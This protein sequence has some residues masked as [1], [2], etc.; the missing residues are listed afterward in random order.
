ML[1]V[2]ARLLFRVGTVCALV[3]VMVGCAGVSASSSGH[4][5]PTLALSPAYPSVPLGGS[6]Q[7]SAIQSGSTTSTVIWAVNGVQSGNSASGTISKTGLYVAPVTAPTGSVLVTATSSTDST[8]YASTT[9][10]LKTSTQTVAVSISPSSPSLQVGGGQQF[11][12]TVTGTS[13]TA[14]TWLVNGVQNGNS[15]YGTITSAGLYTA[16]ATVPSGGVATVTAKSVADSTKSASA[17]VIVSSSTSSVSVKVTPVSVTVAAGATQQFSASVSG[18]TDTSV[19]WLVN[20]VQS[21]NSTDGTIS[22]SGVYAAPNCPSV[23][24]VTVTAQS[25]FDNKAN[26]N[27]TVTISTGVSKS[28]DRFVATDGSDSNDGSACHPWATIQHAADLAQPGWTVHVLPGTYYISSFIWSKASGTTNAH[29]RF[30]G[31][32][33]D[34]TARSWETKIVSSDIRVWYNG[35]SYVDIVGFEMSSSNGS[36]VGGINMQAPYGLVQHNHVY[37]IKS[38]APGA[39][40]FTGGVANYTTVDSNVIEDVATTW[41]GSTDNQGIYISTSYCIVTNNLVYNFAKIGIQIWDGRSGSGNPQHTTV[42]GNT[43]FGGYRGYTLG[44]ENGN[45]ADYNM[46][47]NNIAYNNREYGFV[48]FNSVGTHNTIDYNN[49]YD[50]AAGNWDTTLSHSNDITSDP[51]FVDYRSDGSGDYQLQAGSPN[52]KGTK[53]GASAQ[54]IL[55]FARP[56][57]S[58][59]DVGAYEYPH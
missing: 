37:H 30:E 18:T 12:A 15:T 55:G 8:E 53:T 26:A 24:A 7:F 46:F 19:N 56:Q 36:A 32:Q 16:P 10:A 2:S 58:E 41:G 3:A 33:Y 42:S 11:T 39:A 29:I 23:S 27:S 4:T 47:T 14:V 38:D 17:T 54:D 31:S 13:N 59:Y 50:N 35:G 52:R 45:T 51:M 6:L 49:V 34:M 22:S 40:I 48:A 5:S 28:S 9:V 21:G 25:A 57:G 1:N 44:A 20:N 43:V